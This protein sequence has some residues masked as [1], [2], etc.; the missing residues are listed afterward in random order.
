MYYYKEKSKY[1]KVLLCILFPY[2]SLLNLKPIWHWYTRASPRIHFQ[3]GKEHILSGK[4]SHVTK[5]DLIVQ[6]R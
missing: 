3:V 1:R 5:N 6:L 4:L 2:A